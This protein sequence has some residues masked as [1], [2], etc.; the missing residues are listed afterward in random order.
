MRSLRVALLLVVLLTT[1][2]A[3][4]LPARGDGSFARPAQQS[5]QAGCNALQVVLI[6]DE[7][8]SMSQVINGRAPSDPEGLRFFGSADTARLLSTLHYIIFPSSTMQMALVHFGDR[9]QVGLDWTQFKSTSQSEHDQQLRDLAP[10]FTPM[11]SLGNTNFLAAF[12][13]ASSLFDQA[14]PQVNGCPV[15]AVVVLTDGQPALNRAGFSWQDHMTELAD[16]V[17]NYMPPSS[18]QIFVIGID[19]DNTYWNDVKPYWD[20]VVGDP[21]RAVRAVDQQDMT[22]RLQGITS[23]LTSNL[24]GGRTGFNQ[25]CY[26]GGSISIPPFVQQVEL[27]LIKSSPDQHLDVRD[28]TGRLEPGRTD[29]KVGVSG[30]KDPI[31]T[32]TVNNPLP[33]LWQVQ[34]QLSPD[35]LARCQVRVSRFNAAPKLAAPGPGANLVQFKRTPIQMLIRDASE[36]PLPDY[37]DPRYTVQTVT[38]LVGPSK[39]ALPITLQSQPGYQFNGEVIPLEAGAN[40]LRV[41]ATTR[42]PDNTDFVVFDQPIATFQVA[43]VQLA[44]TDAVKGST[45]QYRP[46]TVKFSVTANQQPV[47]PD[48]PITG[49]VTLTSP[50]GS[51][52]VPITEGPDGVYSVTFK[53]AVSGRHELAYRFSIDTPKGPVTLGQDKLSFDVT[54]TKLVRA[55]IVAPEGG[56]FIATDPF[57]RPTGLPLEVQLKTDDGRAIGPGE[58]GAVDPMY[59]FKL[60]ILDAQ[61]NDRSAETKMSNTG[62]PGLYRLEPNTLGRGHYEIAVIPNTQLAEDYEWASSEW[63]TSAD[64][65][66]NPWFFGV[67]AAVGLVGV[68]GVGVGRREIKQRAHPL[69]GWIEVYELAMFD[70]LYGSNDGTEETSYRKRILREELPTQRNRHVINVSGGLLRR[71][72]DA[73][74]VKRIIVTCSN[75]ED[76][77]AGRALVEVELKDGGRPA[78]V[79]GPNTPALSVGL[80]YYVEK[81][82]RAV[83]MEGSGAVLES[84]DM[85]SGTR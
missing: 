43:P 33:G 18:H 44:V 53:P 83:V 84:F 11:K 20:R 26:K 79:L 75:D 35:A 81:G 24:S 54:P 49:T 60:R 69:S 59:P 29:V 25:E 68:A 5:P 52:A 57:L 14:Q 42:N 16:Y 15:R 40:E 80:G 3:T 45:K 4:S 10:S 73:N 21:S 9:P 71:G 64:G 74:P 22:S 66:I 58:V 39:A 31:E 76:S 30:L 6:V 7:S 48:L 2:F 12:Q 63:K 47:K 61:N 51:Q 36:S 23:Q 70:P 34:S 56:Q 72:S 38:S 8:G 46:S 17:Q 77:K 65:R 50:T 41:K 78:T 27:T 1:L 28:Q 67:L 32:L 19:K 55:E 13:T 62:K 82:P 85:D 37:A